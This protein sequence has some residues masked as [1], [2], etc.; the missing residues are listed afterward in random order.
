MSRFSRRPSAKPRLESLESRDVPAT[1]L[2]LTDTNALL[3]FDSTNTTTPTSTAITGL[4]TGEQVLGIDYRPSNGQLYAVTD[5]NRILTINASTGAATFVASL[6][7][8][9]SDTTNPFTTGMTGTL[10]GTTS[11]GLDFNPTVDR[12]RLVTDTDVNLRINVDTG[13][14]ITDGT[15]AFG[16]SDSNSGDNPY[17]VAAAYA[18]N[19][20]GSTATTL[21]DLNYNNVTDNNNNALLTQNPANNGTLATVG[22]VNAAGFITVPTNTGF[23]ILTTGGG[24]TATRTDTGYA[25]LNA[26]TGS[27]NLYTVNLTTGAATFVRNLGT[28]ST[29]ANFR[30]LAVVPPGTLNFSVDAYS[31][32]ENGGAFTVTV[33]R[34]GGSLGSVSVDYAASAGTATANQD[35]TPTTGTLTFADGVTTQTFM[36]QINDDQAADPGETINLALTNATGESVIGARGNATITIRDNESPTTTLYSVTN[37]TSGSTLLEFDSTAPGT[38]RRTTSIAGLSTGDRIAGIDF[39]PAT[40]KLY[41]LVVNGTASRLVTINTLTGTAVTV[42]NLN[43]GGTPF[44]LTGTDFGFDFNPTVDRIRVVGNDG[45]NLVVNPDTGAVTVGTPIVAT[46]SVVG[47]AYTNSF[48]GATSTTLYA[49]DSTNPDMLDTQDPTTGALTPVGALGVDT[50]NMVGFD[51]TSNNLA[52]A[53]LTATGATSS[54]LY[55]VNLGTGAATSLGT[56]ASSSTLNGLAAFTVNDTNFTATQRFVNRLYMDILGRPADPAGLQAFSNQIDS[57]TPR[58][59]VASALVNSQEARMNAVTEAF[60]RFLGRNPDSTGLNGFTTFLNNGGT[61]QQLAANIVGSQEYFQK[62]GGTNSS[63]LAAAY[64]SLLGR[65]IDAA[66]LAAFNSQLQSGTSRY[67]VALQ[68]ATSQEASMRTVNALYNRYLLR[69]ADPTGLNGFTSFLQ[70]GGR[71]EDVAIALASSQEYFNQTR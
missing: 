63:F 22:T 16:G 19:F 20:S 14:V 48:S 45:Q 6:T 1:L 31:A 24:G 64:Q 43:T 17:V 56:V 41:A 47:S 51:I 34:S 68:I 33:T 11:Y 67:S 46:S 25:I 40:G 58:S 66:G 39:R 8:D 3:R 5:A 26:A 59:S 7:A 2:G 71:V 27:R 9:T 50:G 54:Q 55:S 52:F 30:E 69:N 21:Y 36:V 32:N 28:F 70:R 37:G 12:L 35:F 62:N 18:G 10:A 60:Q 38:I 49:I 65:P 4:N 23:D 53:T 29:S 42:A 13:T 57:G 44:V 61:L 15:L